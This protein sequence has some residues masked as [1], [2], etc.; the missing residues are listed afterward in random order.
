MVK[1]CPEGVKVRLSTLF[2]DA[3]LSVRIHQAELEAI[4]RL[5]R[6]T[7]TQRRVLEQMI[8]GIPNKLGSGLID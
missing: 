4:E 5:S 7:P 3:D 6:L 2:D 8:T 1:L